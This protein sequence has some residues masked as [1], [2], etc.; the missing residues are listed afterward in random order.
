MPAIGTADTKIHPHFVDV[1]IAY[2]ENLEHAIAV[3]QQ[4]CD[5]VAQ[6]YQDDL[7]TLRAKGYR[8]TDYPCTGNDGRHWKSYHI[9]AGDN[10][11]KI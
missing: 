1:G 7:D 9:Q 3:M 11:Y 10:A 8:Q 4:A 6:Q 2:E 5:K